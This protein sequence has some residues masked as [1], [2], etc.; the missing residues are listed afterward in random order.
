MSTK[1]KTQKSTKATSTPKVVNGAT[2][3]ASAPKKAESNNKTKTEEEHVRISINDLKSMSPQ[4]RWHLK[5]NLEAVTQS[6]PGRPKIKSTKKEAAKKATSKVTNKTNDSEVSRQKRW[7]LKKKAEKLEALKNKATKEQV[8]E[9]KEIRAFLKSLGAPAP[10]VKAVTK[11]TV[12][13]KATV[14]ATP[15]AKAT[16]TRMSSKDIK[17]K[18]TPPAKATKKITK[19]NDL[20]PKITGKIKTMS[21]K[22]ERIDELLSE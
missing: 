10:L 19:P 11:S 3:K 1:T 4:Q 9:A 2:E 7:H 18:A 6:G 16:K 22:L 12:K 13:A 21:S 8:N 14:K 5:K 17:A 20:I 15:P